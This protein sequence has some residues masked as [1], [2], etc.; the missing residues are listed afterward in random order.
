MNNNNT[1]DNNN[2]ERTSNANSQRVQQPW[3]TV[4][5][6]RN[7]PAVLLKPS[8]VQSRSYEDA[9]VPHPVLLD[10]DGVA[11]AHREG[12][13]S[14][15]SQVVAKLTGIVHS[16][17]QT[18][19]STYV[20]NPQPFAAGNACHLTVPPRY[21]KWGEMRPAM[22]LIGAFGKGAMAARDAYM[23]RFFPEIDDNDWSDQSQEIALQTNFA[24]YSMARRLTLIKQQ[25]EAEGNETA[26]PLFTWV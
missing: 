12:G 16:P 19:V 11:A 8:N 22:N 4:P 13:I 25:E 24:D 15:S 14:Q 7:Q 3:G 20:T 18:L 1:D 26:C 5:Q 23:R 17:G 6:R 9:A 2:N 21:V 10:S